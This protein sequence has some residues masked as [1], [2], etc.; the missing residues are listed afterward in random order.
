MNGEQMNKL[1]Y[2]LII[3]AALAHWS[4]QSPLSNTDITDP[5]MIQ[6]QIQVLMETDSSGTKYYYRAD[7][8]DRQLRYVELMNGTVQVNGE[9]LILVR[10]V[11]GSY[12]LTD[13][14]LIKYQL[15]TQYNFTV[16][17]SDKSQYTASVKTPLAALSN[18]VVPSEQVKT[19][20]LSLSWVNP[21]TS[22]TMY[23]M[24]AISF[25]TDTSIGLESRKVP[26]SN[27]SLGT[28]DLQPSEFTS[29]QGVST[30]LDITLHSEDLGKIDPRFYA[31]SRAFSHQMITKSVIL[32]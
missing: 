11:L 31:G 12:Y 14:H 21:D 32:K 8:Y 1:H 20:S 16:T 25:K 28:F 17:L 23:L 10:D 9:Q 29:S 7:I 22:A 19:Q 15:N 13:D 5:S 24:L 30:A 3:I 26:I 18:F 27:T 2:P 4:C 6:P